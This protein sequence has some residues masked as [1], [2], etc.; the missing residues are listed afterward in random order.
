MIA[1]FHYFKKIKRTLYFVFQ[2]GFNLKKLKLFVCEGVI[3]ER[4]TTIA[5]TSFEGCN[6]IF[7]NS[8]VVDCSVGA[9]SYIGPG[10][11]FYKTH[12]GAYCSIAGGVHAG[13]GIHPTSKFVST[14]PAFLRNTFDLLYY[15][16]HEGVP[17]SS[18]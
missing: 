9:F 18:L 11:S 5:G 4:S 13:L 1:M 8:K 14:H 17:I 15:T 3:C 6:R 12:I 2:I 7:S 10:C 16:F